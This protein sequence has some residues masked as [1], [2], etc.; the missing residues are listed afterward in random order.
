MVARVE[1]PEEPH[2]LD[3]WS[4]EGGCKKS[5][6]SLN[7]SVRSADAVNQAKLLFA[8]LGADGEGVQQVERE[9]VSQRLVHA[10]SHVTLAEDLHTDN[11][12]AGLASLSQRRHDGGGICIHMRSDGVHAREHDLDPRRFGRGA[13]GPEGMARAA[14]GADNSLL[15]GFR[16]GVHGARLFSVQSSSVRQCIMRMSM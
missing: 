4:P 9:G 11:R 8:I 1:R 5:A 16:D 13:K 3:A 12:L 15:L 7:L 2:L 6:D 10:R 14:V